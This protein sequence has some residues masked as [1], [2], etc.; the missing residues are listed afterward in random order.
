V[1]F[2]LNMIIQWHTTVRHSQI[3]SE[4]TPPMTWKCIPLYKPV[5]NGN[6]TFWE[7]RRSSTLN[8]SLCSSY[9]HRGSCRMT[10]I[11]SGTPTCNSSISTSSIRQGEKIMSLT[12][13]V[14]L[15]WLHSP[16][17][18]IPMDMRHWSGP[19]FINKIRILPTPIKS[20]V[21]AWLS[22]IFIFRTG[23]FSIWAISVFLQASVKI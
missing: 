20:W 16:L 9:K 10:A 17:C 18:S 21:H 15:S 13:L 8:T 1:S 4:N 19:N 23:Y 11:R 6:I 22:L 5:I 2:S 14:D 7:R 3:L 12:S